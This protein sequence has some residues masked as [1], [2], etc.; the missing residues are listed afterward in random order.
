MSSTAPAQDTSVSGARPRLWRTWRSN[1]DGVTAVEFGLIAM[2]FMLMLFGIIGAGLYFFTVFSLENAVER[3]SRIIRTGQAQKSGMNGEQ[4][5]Q[6][7]CGYVPSFVDCTNKLRV[8]VQNYASSSAITTETIP[9]CVDDAHALL[10]SSVYEPGTASQIVLVV[11]CFEWDMAKNLPFY[12]FGNMKGGGLL[13]QAATTFRTEPY[14][15][16]N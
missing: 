10:N 1:N 8:N 9:K 2:P 13:I 6:Q 11:A 12:N 14:D 5:K 7:V 15:P 3:A 16:T 4:F